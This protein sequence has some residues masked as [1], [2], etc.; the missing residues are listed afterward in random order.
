MET[1]CVF[2]K[3]NPAQ[4]ELAKLPFEIDRIAVGETGNARQP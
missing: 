3:S 2:V 4:Q 1:N